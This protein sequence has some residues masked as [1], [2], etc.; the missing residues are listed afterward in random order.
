MSPD[1]VTT[2][3]PPISLA[4]A[5]TRQERRKRDPRRASG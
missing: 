5:S 3:S 4:V 2:S 1:L